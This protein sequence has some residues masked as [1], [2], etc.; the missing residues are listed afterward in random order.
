MAPLAPMTQHVLYS[1]PLLRSG[2]EPPTTVMLSSLAAAHSMDTD[3]D[4]PPSMSSA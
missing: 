3:G 1:L 4:S 2:T